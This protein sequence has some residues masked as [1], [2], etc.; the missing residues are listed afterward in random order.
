MNRY[1]LTEV[2]LN[3][4]IEPMQCLHKDIP[5]PSCKGI[6]APQFNMA[7]GEYEQTIQEQ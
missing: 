7:T 4:M 3:L 1:M 6:N 5:F 2:F